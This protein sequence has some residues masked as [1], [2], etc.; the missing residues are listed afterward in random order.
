MRVW[1]LELKGIAGKRRSND[2]K[3]AR[4]IWKEMAMVIGD[5]KDLQCARAGIEWESGK[6]ASAQEK[7]ESMQ[8]HRPD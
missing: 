3:R 8:Q 2:E 1:R 6:S 5:T 4:S 7:R